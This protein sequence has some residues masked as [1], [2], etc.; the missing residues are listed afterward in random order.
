[1]T[2]RKIPPMKAILIHGMGR[3]TASMAIL[4]RRL[5]ARGLATCALGYMAAFE[6]FDPCVERLA[7][8]IRRLAEEEPFLLVG[9]SLGAVLV[10]GALPRIA[11]LPLAAC[12]LLAPPQRACRAARF[13]SSHPLYRW[14]NGEMGQLLAD[15]AFF[16]GLPL[17]QVPTR[18]FAGNAGPRAAWLPFEGEPNDGILAV[19]ETRAR[20]DDE[21][22]EVPALHTFIMNSRRVAEGIVELAGVR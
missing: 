14:V 7:E 5:R 11:D 17:P 18:V 19:E 1:M 15:P 20:D 12:V 8:R 9:H 13:F 6:P 10:R 16:A 3:T 2:C 4:S 22:I 21:V